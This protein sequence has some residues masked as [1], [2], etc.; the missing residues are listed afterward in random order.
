MEQ[1]LCGSID[2][3]AIAVTDLDE[4]V[5]WYCENLGFV[6]VERRLTQGNTTAMMSA[7]MKSGAAVVVLLQGTSPD[8]QVSKFVEKFGPGVQ[9]L[10]FSVTN[11]DSALE[12]LQ[13]RG[14]AADIDI[15]E[16]VGIRQV[17]L[18]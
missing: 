3:V 9:H 15:V 14:A 16:G 1:Y 11:L 2:H 4:A 10:A 18:R 5:R 13:Q 8:S 6:E 7:V 12:R 17:F